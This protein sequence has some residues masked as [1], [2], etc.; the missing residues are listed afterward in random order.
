MPLAESEL[1]EEEI[2]R[3]TKFFRLTVS[4][5]ERTPE[6]IEKNLV[7]T[8]YRRVAKIEKEKS[9]G[10]VQ[11]RDGK[12]ALLQKFAKRFYMVMP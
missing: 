11:N 7:K 5:P 9:P 2:G 4:R 6:R 1:E 3:V 10:Q 12:R 8:F